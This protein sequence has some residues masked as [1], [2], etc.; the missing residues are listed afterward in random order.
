MEDITS[1]IDILSAA[2]KCCTMYMEFVVFRIINVFDYYFTFTK[3]FSF[4]CRVAA[5]CITHPNYLESNVFLVTIHPW[6]CFA[7]HASCAGYSL[8][9][10]APLTFNL[11]KPSFLTPKEFQLSCSESKP[12]LFFISLKPTR[13]PVSGHNILSIFL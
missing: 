10:P 12:F 7:T 3:T 9:L 11:L 1:K 8:F 6:P 13:C 4:K 5:G 2:R